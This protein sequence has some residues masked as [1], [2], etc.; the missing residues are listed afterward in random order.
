M[1]VEE[2]L[3]LTPNDV[4]DKKLT[5]RNPK[6]GKEQELVFIPQQVDDRLKEYVRENCTDPDQKIFQISYEEVR[7]IV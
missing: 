4:N 6:S 3:K 2:V 7:A 1:K 5:I